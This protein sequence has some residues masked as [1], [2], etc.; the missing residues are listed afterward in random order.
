[1]FLKHCNL[2]FK[3]CRDNYF[4]IDVSVMEHKS[5][6]QDMLYGPEK[7]KVL[8]VRHSCSIS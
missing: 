1:M 7:G 3:N 8:N 4:D 5:E 2:T 6:V